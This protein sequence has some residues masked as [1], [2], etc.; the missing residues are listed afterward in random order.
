MKRMLFIYL[1]Q[2][3]Y[4]FFEVKYLL[5]KPGIL[6][7]LFSRYTIHKKIIK[8]CPNVIDLA[9]YKKMPFGSKFKNFITP[10]NKIELEDRELSED[11]SFAHRWRKICGGKIYANVS[12]DI[13]HVAEIVIKS[14]YLDLK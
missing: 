14:K 2:E 1:I 9:R 4:L 5:F 12:T 11:L 7:F 13:E 3:R 10:F 8:N 6:H